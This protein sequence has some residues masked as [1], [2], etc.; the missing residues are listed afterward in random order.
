MLIDIKLKDK[1]G[2]LKT[3]DKGRYGVGKIVSD[4]RTHNRDP[5]AKVTIEVEVCDWKIENRLH[6][7]CGSEINDPFG[8]R[9]RDKAFIRVT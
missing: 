5:S 9:R 3:D 8:G 6:V 2:K 7:I 4:S 1:L